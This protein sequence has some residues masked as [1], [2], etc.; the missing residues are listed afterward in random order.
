[1][2][3]VSR[4]YSR[5]HFRFDLILTTNHP[6]ISSLPPHSRP[7]F[8]NGLT[9]QVCSHMHIPALSTAS[10]FKFAPTFTFSLCQ[11]S[12]VL[13]LPSRPKFS[14]IFTSP[15][16]HVSSLLPYSCS[17]FANS[18]KFQVSPHIHVPALSSSFQANS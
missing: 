17:R 1:M 15:L 16:S 12:H 4:P 13:S 3:L 8:V 2:L 18:L 7:S 9:F 14:S 11:Q 6:H 5:S 10:R